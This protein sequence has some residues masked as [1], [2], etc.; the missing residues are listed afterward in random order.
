MQGKQL[1]AGTAAAD[2]TLESTILLFVDFPDAT[3]DEDTHA[4]TDLLSPGIED[5]NDEVPDPRGRRGR[6]VPGQ[7]PR[8]RIG[9]RPEHP[10]YSAGPITTRAL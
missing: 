3:S 4:I 10:R 8:L 7:A 1:G 2:C 6:E 9:A 5:Y